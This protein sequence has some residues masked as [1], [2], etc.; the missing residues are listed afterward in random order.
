MNIYQIFRLLIL[1]RKLRKHE[2]WTR[3]NLEQHINKALKELRIYA[4]SQ[5]PFYKKF[6]EGLMNRPLRELPVL[7]K[8][9]LMKNWDDI[10]TDRSVKL[11][12]V[13]NFL[14]KL[15]GDRLFK[16]R[17]Y[18]NS[19]AGSSGLKGIFIYNL[20]EWL[21]IMSSYIGEMTGQV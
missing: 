3:A 11:V 1:R 7:T 5:S 16:N 19:T 17:Y 18:V 6:H 13:Q 8:V 21:T 10:I 4:Y 12:D 9:E 15:Q 14:K 2:D 20:E